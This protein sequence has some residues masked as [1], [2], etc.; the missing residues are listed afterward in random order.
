MDSSHVSLSIADLSQIQQLKHVGAWATYKG[1]LASINFTVVNVRDMGAEISG[2][3]KENE[4]VKKK[5]IR[6]DQGIIP[7]TTVVDTDVDKDGGVV[8]ASGADNS[9][10]AYGDSGESASSGVVGASGADNSDGA[11]G[12]SGESASSSGWVNNV[13]AITK[14]NCEASAVAEFGER[15]TAK[16]RLQVGW[17]KHVKPG[18]S[19][20]SKGDWAAYWNIYAGGKDDNNRYTTVRKG[21]TAHLLK[22]AGAKKSSNARF[23]EE[24]SSASG[25]GESGGA[26]DRDSDRDFDGDS[27]A[28]FGGASGASDE[29]RDAIPRVTYDTRSLTMA[30]VKGKIAVKMMD[31]LIL[32][33]DPIL[34][35]RWTYVAVTYNHRTKRLVL[36]QDG[37]ARISASDVEPLDASLNAHQFYIGSESE[38]PPTS[39]PM[40]QA[41]QI[42]ES[43]LEEGDEGGIVEGENRGGGKEDHAMRFMEARGGGESGGNSE[44]ESGGYS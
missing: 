27:G 28:D 8:G 17:W 36:Y 39:H 15:V 35:G 9:D 5:V 7:A 30:V 43:L 29:A 38:T 12:D 22:M 11:Y 24:Y 1:L 31:R 2:W 14:A 13:A 44:G 33:P 25:A 4:V 34:P 20:Q 19:I 16:R 21:M 26:S 40:M 18:C 23:R 10:E 37:I 41:A 3:E 6:I 42:S 32:C